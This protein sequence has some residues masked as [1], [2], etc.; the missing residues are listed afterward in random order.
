MNGENQQKRNEGELKEL[1]GKHMD[2]FVS[3]MSYSD[4]TEYLGLIKHFEADEKKNKRNISLTLFMENLEIIYAFIHKG[5]GYDIFRGYVCGIEF[6]NQYI[7]VNSKRLTNLMHKS[8]SCIN[9]CLQ[10]LGFVLL[11]QQQDMCGFFCSVIPGMT[12]LMCNS[13]QWCM[14]MS[15]K[16]DTR[17]KGYIPDEI[18]KKYSICTPLDKAIQSLDISFLL[19]DNNNNSNNT[20]PKK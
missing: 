6:G 3:S 9:N 4:Q 1:L 14:R 2:A 18:A 17:F 13:R 7:L 15:P 12:S 19:N 5:D 16:G 8:K 11:R 20:S 10:R